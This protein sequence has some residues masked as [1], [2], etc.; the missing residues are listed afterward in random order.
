MV[1]VKRVRERESTREREKKKKET[2]RHGDG[3]DE[4]PHQRFVTQCGGS[5]FYT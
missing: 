5:L 1:C 4:F 3:F 2:A